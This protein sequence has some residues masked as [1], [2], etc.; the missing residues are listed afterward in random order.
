M[1][2]VCVIFALLF[3]YP[4]PCPSTL[5]LSLFLSFSLSNTLSVYRSFSCRGFSSDDET[6]PKSGNRNGDGNGNGGNV[7]GLGGSLGGNGGGGGDGGPTG[8]SLQGPPVGPNPF[9]EAPPMFA[10][11]EYKKGYVMRK[12]C[13][14]TNYKKSKCVGAGLPARSGRGPGRHRPD[15]PNAPRY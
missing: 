8:G 2:T 12:C 15:H 1:G 9:L 3:R 5:S 11:V 6:D 7:N 10:A 13:Y 4:F 14:D